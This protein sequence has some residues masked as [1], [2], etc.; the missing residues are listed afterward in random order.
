MVGEAC[1]FPLGGACCVLSRGY[2]PNQSL[3]SPSG[4]R[5][6]GWTMRRMIPA[7]LPRDIPAWAIKYRPVEWL[8]RR[9]ATGERLAHNYLLRREVMFPD[10]GVRDPEAWRGMVARG[11]G[12]ECVRS[13]P[14]RSETAKP[15]PYVEPAWVAPLREKLA[16]PSDSS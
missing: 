9:G 1:H 11:L 3:L 2:L 13:A 8:R 10:H 4:V 7:T 6:G 16:L 5:W 15:A 14:M 12:V